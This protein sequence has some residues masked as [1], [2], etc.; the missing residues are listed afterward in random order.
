MSNYKVSLIVPCYNVTKIVG[1]KDVSF[2]N[3]INSIKNQT[4]GFENIEL[5]LINNGSTDSTADILNNLSK[6]YSNV[7]IHTIPENTGGPSI[8]RNIGI[9]NATSDYIM[10]LDADD[11]M[12]SDCVKRLYDEIISHDVDLVKSNYSILTEEKI[13]KYDSGRNERFITK[14][15]SKDMIYIVKDFM[16]GSIYNKDFLI[17][18]NIRF[19]NTQAEDSLFLSKCYN[20]TNKDIIALNDYYS[21]IYTANN[22]NSLSHS[23]T[24]KQIKDYAMIY[25]E[26]IDSY[27]KYKQSN[28]FILLNIENYTIVLIGSLLRSNKSFNT[29]K[30]MIKEIK[31][32]QLK[33]KDYNIQ[34]PLMWK[35][36][37]ILIMHEC[38]LL[39]Q[40][41]SVIINFIFE[42]S[43]FTKIFRNSNYK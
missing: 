33:Y 28:E 43:V 24:L 26:T 34:L 32:F 21:I 7:K 6:T 31:S 20:L 39:I 16:W 37:Y 41:S 9:E 11:R 3:T 22:T 2:E 17:K 5:L 29:K 13:L 1:G 14:P 27:I 10:L 30:K 19:P 12:D 15:K 18:N 4:I 8:P 35:I 42:N 38:N 23:F 40:F 25:E 36:F